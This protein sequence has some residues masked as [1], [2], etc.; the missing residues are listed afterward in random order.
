MQPSLRRRLHISTATL[1]TPTFT[2]L[3]CRRGFNG[4]V[5]DILTYVLACTIVGRRVDS[6]F[7]THLIGQSE[8]M[9]SLT[10]SC[11]DRQSSYFLHRS[12]IG[13]IKHSCRQEISKSFSVAL[14]SPEKRRARALLTDNASRF[15]LV[16][17]RS[18]PSK[19]LS[20]DS[21]AKPIKRHPHRAEN[22]AL[23]H[24]ETISGTLRCSGQADLE[25]VSPVC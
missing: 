19:G 6:T 18:P 5:L 21:P 13:K 16:N 14:I 24:G 12:G 10:R 11:A 7:R 17:A 15:S 1:I 4:S 2:A 25:L 9:N 20:A 3:R 22:H 23:H 8:C